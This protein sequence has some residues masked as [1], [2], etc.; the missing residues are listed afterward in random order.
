CEEPDHLAAIREAGVLRVVSR[1]GPTT[2]Y[3]DRHGPAGFEY[4]LARRFAE[5]LGVDLEIGTEHSLEALFQVLERGEADIAAPGLT[6][7][8]ERR[9]RL[10]FSVP[11]MDVTQHILYRSGTRRPR[12]P[13][14]LLGKR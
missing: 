8:P 3:Q 4:E 1:N 6:V 5:Q 11:Y 13:E 10:D 2:Y 12:S 14:D 9:H 7:T